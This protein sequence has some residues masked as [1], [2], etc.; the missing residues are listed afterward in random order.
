GNST[1]TFN[2]GSGNYGVKV[3]EL[4][5]MASLT[6]MTITGT[7][8]GEGSKGVIVGSED[9]DATGMVTMNMTNVGISGVEKGVLMNGAGTL[10]MTGV[11]ISGVKMGVEATN[12]TLEIKG[13]T[14][15]VFKNGDRNYGVK[16]QNGVTMASLKSVTIRGEGAGG[17]GEGS[18]GVIVDRTKM[19]MEEV[20]I[21]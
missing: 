11:Q 15:I 7:G 16:V 1:I 2:N 8:S 6:N 19:I 3:G 20:R 4:V 10:T 17:N 18:K 14:T 9:V 12:G 21:S 13:G 5:T